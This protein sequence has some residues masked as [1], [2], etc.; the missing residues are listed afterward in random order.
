[1]SGP[2][3]VGSHAY[4]TVTHVLDQD[5]LE[6]VHVDIRDIRYC[7]CKTGAIKTR[8][9]RNGGKKNGGKM[10]DREPKCDF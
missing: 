3:I 1:M 5:Q 2:S 9:P 8:T 7:T 10:V 4:Y 6:N